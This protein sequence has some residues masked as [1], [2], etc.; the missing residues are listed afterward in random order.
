[1]YKVAVTEAL[2]N[3]KKLA[4]GTEFTEK[5]FPKDVITSCIEK[6]FI[7]KVNTNEKPVKKVEIN[8]P[9]TKI[10]DKN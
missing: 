10:S 2:I 5:D 8:K 6:G 4:G 7:V 9:T 1:M 3:G